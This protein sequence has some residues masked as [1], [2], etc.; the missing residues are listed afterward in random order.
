M[1]NLLMNF[2]GKSSENNWRSVSAISCKTKK[3]SKEPFFLTAALVLL[4]MIAGGFFVSLLKMIVFVVQY[5]YIVLGTV[6][7]LVF[8]KKTIFAVR[9]DTLPCREEDS[10]L[11]VQE[12]G[13]RRGKRS[14]LPL[15]DEW[16]WYLVYAIV[17]LFVFV[18]GLA[19]QID[20]LS[21][22]RLNFGF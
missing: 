5:W 14:V 11:P 12:E 17:F 7:L 8:L 15:S 2:D 9:D 3:K 10:A 21:S 4:V 22:F 19:S 6:L 16:F 20:S 18:V 1:G 13:Q